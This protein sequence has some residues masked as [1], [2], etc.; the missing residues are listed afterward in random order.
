MREVERRTVEF[1]LATGEA[2]DFWRACSSAMRE[3]MAPLR[4]FETGQ[5]VER[6]GALE[7][8]HLEHCGHVC[9][10]NLFLCLGSQRSI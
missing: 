9:V 7:V 4:R 2:A 1:D 5:Q 8:I 3:S 6:E 10:K